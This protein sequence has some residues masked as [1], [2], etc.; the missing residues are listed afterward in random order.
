M[1]T[2]DFVL[3]APQIVRAARLYR[4]GNSLRQIAD[5]FQVSAMAVKNALTFAGVA[6]RERHEARRLRWHAPT[7]PA[8]PRITARWVR[9]V[10]N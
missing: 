5:H 3:T 7:L 8:M 6:L 9:A 10:P 4:E 2:G 1:A